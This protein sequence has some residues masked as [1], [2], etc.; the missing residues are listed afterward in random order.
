MEGVFLV[1]HRG[2]QQRWL[3]CTPV[4]PARPESVLIAVREALL[5]P[6]LRRGD[7][8]R[9][10]VMAGL[11]PAIHVFVPKAWMPGTRPGMTRPATPCPHPPLSSASGFAGAKPG[12]AVLPRKGGDGSKW[13]FSAFPLSTPSFRRKPES[14]SDSAVWG[15]A[16]WAPAFA[17]V[18]KEVGDA[19]NHSSWPGSSRPSTSLSP[20]RCPWMPG[21]RPGMTTVEAPRPHSPSE[22]PPAAFAD[23]R[24]RARTA[25]RQG[26]RWEPAVGLGVPSQRRRLNGTKVI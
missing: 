13:P 19:P 4:I 22:A 26:G 2:E 16:A 23:A 20:E 25:P 8:V 14:S 3:R 9:I 7:E 12:S 15:S 17:G 1:I 5:G 10:A 24:N 11:V 6:G 18:T 21:T